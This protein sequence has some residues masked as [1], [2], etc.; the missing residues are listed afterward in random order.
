MTPASRCIPCS[1]DW[2]Y[3]IYPS[4]FNCCQMFPLIFLHLFL[5][6]TLTYSHVGPR[7]S[8]NSFG[9]F[10]DGVPDVVLVYT[11]QPSGPEPAPVPPRCRSGPVARTGLA[12]KI[13]LAAYETFGRT[14]WH[15]SFFHTEAQT[16]RAASCLRRRVS[17]DWQIGRF[18]VHPPSEFSPKHFF[19]GGWKLRLKG[20]KGV[21]CL[22]T[23]QQKS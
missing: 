20:M 8:Q 7:C 12:G 5:S 3:G 17:E 13:V 2:N 10:W 22:L 14:G 9:N 4:A 11:H 1:P 19:G 18:F 21:F 15:F 23:H 6:L 16:N